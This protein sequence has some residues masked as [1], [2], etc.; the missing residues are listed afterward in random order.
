MS[1]QPPRRSRLAKAADTS[2]NLMMV[3]TAGFVILI[4]LAFI[5]LGIWAATIIL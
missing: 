5:A 2:A 4:V 1:S 3:M